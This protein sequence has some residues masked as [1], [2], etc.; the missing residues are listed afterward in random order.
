[1]CQARVYL[2]NEGSQALVAQDVIFLEEVPEGVRLGS[3][4][5]EPKLVRAR[6]ASVDFLKHTVIL[7]PAD[8]GT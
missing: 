3:F 1:M 4:F 5:E 6:V 2:A 8:A 7:V